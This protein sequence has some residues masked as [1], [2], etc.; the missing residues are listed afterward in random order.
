ME[1][2]LTKTAIHFIYGFFHVSSKKLNHLLLINN[3]Y[4]GKK[5][6]FFLKICSENCLIKYGVVRKKKK[7]SNA[8][9]ENIGH[10]SCPML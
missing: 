4:R 7:K 10:S 3:L 5:K 9:M 6:E 2:G 1:V 8:D